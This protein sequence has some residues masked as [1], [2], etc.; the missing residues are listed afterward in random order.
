MAASQPL[1]PFCYDPEGLAPYDVDIAITHCGVCHS[2]IA[3]LDNE[4]GWTVYPFV[5]GHE[6]IGTVRAVGPAVT[7]IAVGQRV[8]VGWQRSSCMECEWCRRGEETCCPNQQKTCIGHHGG[9]ADAIRTD[10]R[11][12]FPI[13][14]ALPAA[15]AA[16]LLCAGLTVYTPLR[17]DARPASRVG[18][19]GIG[20]LG[21][22]AVRFA[23]AMGCEVTAF[24]P[25]PGEEER[26]QRLGAHHCVNTGDSAQ[27]G[28]AAGSLDFLLSTVPVDLDWGMW[29]NILRPTGV[30][31]L[32]GI[33]PGMISVPAASLIT[34]QKSIR[35]TTMKNRAMMKEMLLFAALH[36]IVADVE[37]LPLSD[38]NEAIQR[39][40]KYQARYRMVL[41]T[42]QAV[43]DSALRPERAVALV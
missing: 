5:P 25:S 18:V 4:W 26:A 23:R 41:E 38:V 3:L 32:V 12:V 11:F 31:T 33:P 39:V 2:D 6:I 35:G 29:L 20:G 30:L 34:N 27:M 8:G 16:P 19:I 7:I 36:G 21:H 22:L 28:R 15:G 40:R 37:I 17:L 42:G 9:F 24:F 13:P 14:D 1:E 43:P 10:S